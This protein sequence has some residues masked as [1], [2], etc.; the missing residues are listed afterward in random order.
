ME[1]TYGKKRMI[2]EIQI[3]VLHSKMGYSVISLKKLLPLT[4]NLPCT[5]HCAS[6]K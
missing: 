2:K 3:A 5:R 6:L 4:K 1:D